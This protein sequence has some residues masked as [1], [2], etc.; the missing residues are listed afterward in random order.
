MA[1][2]KRM[3]C[4][5]ITMI[6]ILV[7]IV[8]QTVILIDDEAIL[9]KENYIKKNASLYAKKCVHDGKCSKGDVTFSR[10]HDLGY[11]NDIFYNELESYS[12]D[13]YVEYPTYKVNLR[14]KAN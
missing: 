2:G 1:R 7:I 3:I 8:A 10:L 14:T 6:G 13:S 12:L 4:F 9:K 11:I 5:V